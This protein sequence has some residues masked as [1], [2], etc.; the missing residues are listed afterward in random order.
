MK[1]ETDPLVRTILDKRQLAL[2]VTANSFFGFLG[3]QDGGRLPLIE[4]AMCITAKGRALINSVNGYLEK[5]KGGTIVYGDTDSSMVNLHIDNPKDCNPIGEALSKEI[6]GFINHPP[7]KME[8]EKGMRHFLVLKKKMYLYTLTDSDGNEKKKDGQVIVVKKGVAEARRDRCKWF[9]KVS[10]R[11]SR[12]ILSETP[13]H[14]T[15]SVLVDMVKDLLRGNIPIKELVSI[16][17]LG[18]HY[19]SESYFVKVFADNLRR[20]GKIV[21][22][23]DRLEFVVVNTGDPN[24]KVGMRMRSPEIYYERLGTPTEERIDYIYYLEHVLMNPIDKLFSVG[25]NK[26]LEAIKATV[27]YKPKGRYHFKSIEQP[28]KMMIRV[29]ADGN[30][31][32]GIKGLLVPTAGPKTRLLIVNENKDPPNNTPNDPPSNVGSSPASETA[33]NTTVIPKKVPRLVVV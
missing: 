4:G 31:I 9:R 12:L 18:A 1:K 28:I 26:E 11:I 13:M 32:E 2:K 29:I 6:T 27:G 20:L 30:D 10:D 23:G 14:Q 24:A 16:R 19:K 8:F 3:V 7:L 22:A 21:S 17:E 33:Q 15:L 5:T 25:Y